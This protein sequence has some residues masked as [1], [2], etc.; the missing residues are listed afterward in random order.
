MGN[1]DG[2]SL[3]VVPALQV[4]AWLDLLCAKARYAGW[5]EAVLPEFVPWDKV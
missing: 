2:R 5:M 1:Q 3:A 4:V